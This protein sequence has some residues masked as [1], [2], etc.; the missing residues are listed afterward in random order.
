VLY[1]YG[2]L[3]LR[4]TKK[5][6]NPNQFRTE[7][8]SVLRSAPIKRQTPDLRV[9]ELHQQIWP[10]VLVRKWQPNSDR[11]ELRRFELLFLP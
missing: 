2:K 10:W 8:L 11:Y 1:S 9:A 7:T 5:A 4:S 6:S 3:N